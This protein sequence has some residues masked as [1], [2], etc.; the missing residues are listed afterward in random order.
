M[1]KAGRTFAIISLL[2]LGLIWPQIGQCDPSFST[3]E[4]QSQ[5]KT[6]HSAGNH[7]LVTGRWKRTTGTV[8]L[9]KPPIINTTTIKCDK[10]NMTCSEIIAGVVTPRE[11]PKLFEK[12]YLFIEETNYKIINW[13][14]GIINA[15]HEAPVADFELRISL[16]DNVAERKS[17]E[18]KARGSSTSEPKN[19]ESWELE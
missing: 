8:K 7:V 3:D 15:K 9:N 13:S 1:K 16:R 17:R 10:L 19:Y 14:N 11:E 6:I 5:F 18:T 12:P 2:C 4:I